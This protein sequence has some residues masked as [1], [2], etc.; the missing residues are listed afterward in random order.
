MFLHYIL[1]E[2]LSKILKQSKSAATK[3]NF[4]GNVFPSVEVFCFFGLKF[5]LE[6]SC[7]FSY[8]ERTMKNENVIPVPPPSPMLKYISAMF[9]K[10]R[11]NL[12]C[13]INNNY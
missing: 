11:I 4:T 6:F 2:I 10:N 1:S 7:Y 12:Q 5:T 8:N 9:I 13:I 3:E